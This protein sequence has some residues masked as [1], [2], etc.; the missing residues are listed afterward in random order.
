MGRLVY[1]D[2]L[3]AWLREHWGVLSEREALIVS[4]RCG[5]EDGKSWTLKAIGERVGVSKERVRQIHNKAVWKMNKHCDSQAGTG[6]DR[7]AFL[8]EHAKKHSHILSQQEEQVLFLHLGLQDD[9]YW[10]YARIGELIGASRERVYLIL[11]KAAIKIRDAAQQG[12]DH[13]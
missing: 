4:L 13:E 1:G 12:Q 10:S 5:L 8:R 6:D 11:V 2:V 3:L 9:Q 7:L